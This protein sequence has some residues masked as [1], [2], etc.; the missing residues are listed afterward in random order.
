MDC[1]EEGGGRAAVRGV[2]EARGVGG[3]KEPRVAE[4]EAPAAAAEGEVLLGG[5]MDAAATTAVA[6][7]HLRTERGGLPKISSQTHRH[8]NSKISS[9]GVEIS[10]TT[11]SR[12]ASIESPTYSRDGACGGSEIGRAHV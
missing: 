1:G 10:S 12:A 8:S 3:E 9:V 7:Q 5:E 4:E 2:Q 6:C 11:N